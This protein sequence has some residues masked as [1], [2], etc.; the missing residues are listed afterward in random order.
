MLIISG[1]W[2]RYSEGR[3]RGGRGRGGW[4]KSVLIS[5]DVWLDNLPNL[6]RNETHHDL[7]KNVNNY[8][9]YINYNKTVVAP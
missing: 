6:R 1:V 8:N 3:G 2:M 7:T 4:T 9:I 5:C